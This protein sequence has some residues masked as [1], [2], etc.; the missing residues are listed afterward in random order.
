MDKLK[1]FV[2]S[3]PGMMVSMMVL[4]HNFIYC[5]TNNPAYLIDHFSAWYTS[6]IITD[7]NL[8]NSF[9]QI[10]LHTFCPVQVVDLEALVRQLQEDLRNERAEKAGIIE[11]R[12]TIKKEKDEV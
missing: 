1:F 12:N 10:I 4:G 2:I 5:N 11:E 9:I 6:R 8:K 3:S 7:D